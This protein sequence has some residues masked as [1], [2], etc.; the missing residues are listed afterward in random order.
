[1][2]GCNV[3]LRILISVGEH[4]SRV[5]AVR[6]VRYPAIRLACWMLPSRWGVGKHH[7]L[8]FQCPLGAWLITACWVAGASWQSPSPALGWTSGALGRCRVVLPCGQS[9]TTVATERDVD[10]CKI[11]ISMGFPVLFVYT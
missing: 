3:D 9:G 8:Y 6:T 1:M 7:R 2:H 11:A 5:L 4:C 10:I